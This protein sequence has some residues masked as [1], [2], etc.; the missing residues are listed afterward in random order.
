MKQMYVD[1]TSVRNYSLCTAYEYTNESEQTSLVIL[2]DEPISE[3]QQ[4]QLLHSYLSEA[5][6]PREA[7][8]LQ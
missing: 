5:S 6:V 1:K 2:V 7:N 4:K 8:P 3:K